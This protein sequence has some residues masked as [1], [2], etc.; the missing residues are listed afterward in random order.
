[1]LAE[2]H[3]PPLRWPIRELFDRFFMKKLSNNSIAPLDFSSV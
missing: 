3:A 1:M 2:V